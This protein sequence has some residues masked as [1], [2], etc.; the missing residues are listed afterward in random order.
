MDSEQPTNTQGAVHPSNVESELRS[1]GQRLDRAIEQATSHDR[2]ALAEH[3]TQARTW[4]NKEL[5]NFNK[6]AENKEENSLGALDETPLAKAG[7]STSVEAEAP[8]D[9]DQQGGNDSDPNTESATGP[10]GPTDDTTSGE[11]T[12]AEDSEPT[13]NPSTESGDQVSTSQP[14]AEAA[15]DTS[16]AESS[17]R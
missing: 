13:S 1:I 4:I 12:A 10:A 15:T 2:T 14:E 6:D 7:N 16:T 5:Y 9:T 8:A 3:L 11:E 17:D